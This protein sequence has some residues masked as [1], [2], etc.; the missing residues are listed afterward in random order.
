MAEQI[1]AALARG[2]TFDESWPP[3][4]LLDD[5]DEA[6]ADDPSALGDPRIVAFREAVRGDGAWQAERVSGRER[7]RRLREEVAAL[8]YAELR[9]AV[10]TRQH[11]LMVVRRWAEQAS[12]A[13][14][15]EAA[16]DLLAIVDPGLLWRLLAIF[17]A[18]DFP[19]GHRPLLPLL[20]HPEPLVVLRAAHALARFR[21]PEL[22]ARA[23]RLIAAADTL[24][25]GLILNRWSGRP[26]AR[27]PLPPPAPERRRRWARRGR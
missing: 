16:E 4:R 24:E 12:E 14:L 15:C 13:A 21:H 19:A 3:W 7:R 26:P 11:S 23:E 9:R 25:P 8:S 27:R 20:D 1:G 17:D 6:F 10:E 22:R 2:V 18:R 5:L